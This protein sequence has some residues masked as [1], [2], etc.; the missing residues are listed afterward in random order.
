MGSNNVRLVRLSLLAR[1]L[2]CHIY[3]LLYN[4]QVI[5]APSLSALVACL[6]VDWAGLIYRLV[7]T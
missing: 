3:I 5:L 6:L 1:F 7:A 4:V 2:Y